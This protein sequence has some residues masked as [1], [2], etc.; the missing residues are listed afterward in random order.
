MARSLESNDGVYF[1]PALV[2]LG[3]PYW[4]PYARGTI[5]GITRGTSQQHFAR[6]ALESMCYQTRDV[7]E[8]MSRD[9][10]IQIRQMKADGGAVG[11]GFL[12][13]FQSD[14]LG[15]PVDVPRITETTALGAA[16]LAGLATGQWT[17]REEISSLN[18]TSKR[19]EAQM[20]VDERNMLYENWQRAVERA[21]GWVQE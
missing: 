14:M 4:D 7:V 5:V 20:S 19:Y 10:G 1:V 15:V 18:K 11:N 2:G 21:R 8:A 3:A 17:S 12:M 9:S 16:Y 13:Q 6:A